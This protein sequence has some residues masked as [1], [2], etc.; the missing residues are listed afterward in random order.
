V[1][2]LDFTNIASASIA[3]PASGVT[4]VYVDAT[5][6]LLSFKNDSGGVTPTSLYLS[7]QSVTT[8][9][10]GFAADT[11]LVGSAIAIPAGYPKVGT[12]Y[13]VFFDITKT[14]NGT[15]TPIFT[16]RF[17]AAGTTSDP[18]VLTFTFAVGTAVIDT[19]LLEIT[20]HFRTVGA[21]TSAVVA[22]VA[23]LRHGLAAT[24]LTT[25][26]ASG[27]ALIIPAPSGGFNS[28]LANAIM[29]LSVNGGT[30]AAWTITLVQSYLSSL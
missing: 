30:S 13:R 27:H 26:G 8:P 3:T 28:T 14:G 12:Q 29:G 20:T 5:T 16:L 19:G 6:K 11:Y 22:G 17:G 2:E 15:A 4:A 10:A 9:G 7:N 24:G 18:A 21:G 25:T 23:S 1:A